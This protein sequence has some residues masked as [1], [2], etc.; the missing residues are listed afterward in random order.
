MLK[1]KTQF[2]PKIQR[3]LLSHTNL[4]IL[5]IF[6]HILFTILI[7]RVHVRKEYWSFMKDGGLF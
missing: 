4:M 7:F 1:H 5:N 2:L 3:Q 6:A